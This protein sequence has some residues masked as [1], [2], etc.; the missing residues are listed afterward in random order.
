VLQLGGWGETY[1]AVKIMKNGNLV[2]ANSGL[3]PLRP[4]RRVGG[5]SV[6]GSLI[7]SGH[8]RN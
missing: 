2:R 6:K 3:D 8:A 7:A 4:E 1:R 5:E